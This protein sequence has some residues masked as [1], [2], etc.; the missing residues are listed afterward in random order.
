[1]QRYGWQA[2]QQKQNNPSPN[3]EINSN[4]SPIS[5]ILKLLLGNHLE[6]TSQQEKN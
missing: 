6:S 1:M 2:R 4:T 3:S 5:N